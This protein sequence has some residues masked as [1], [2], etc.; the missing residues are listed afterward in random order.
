[1]DEICIPLFWPSSR[2]SL[3]FQK[4]CVLAITIFFGT[5]SIVYSIGFAYV[6]NT[7]ISLFFLFNNS[8]HSPLLGLFFLSAFNPYANA[9]GAMI[10]FCSN[11]GFNWFLAFG[12][13][14]SR[15]M[16]Q[17]FPPETFGCDN[18]FHGNLSS[19]NPY[20]MTSSV[21][22]Y[23]AIESNVYYPENPVL[24]YLFSVAPIWYCLFSVV[25]TFVAG[26]LLSFGYS[27]ARSCSLDVDF[28]FRE[29][30]KQYL[31]YYRIFGGCRPF[32]NRS[33][34]ADLTPTTSPLISPVNYNN[35]D[36]N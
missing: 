29:E 33:P 25:Y 12:S 22:H 20:N 35:E 26:S 34:R 7:M 24:A 31:Y 27:M 36:K 2:L 32:K 3:K 16:S 30:R 14:F 18:E 13:V 6:Q 5:A 8:I 19:L 10:A 9:V 15:L 1:M 28:E 11:L 23:Q 4:H 17:E 21:H